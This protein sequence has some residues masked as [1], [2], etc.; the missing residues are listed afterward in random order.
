MYHLLND[1]PER[2]FL[3]GLGQDARSPVYNYRCF[4]LRQ[5][6]SATATTAGRILLGR[7]DQGNLTVQLSVAPNE[8]DTTDYWLNDWV[9]MTGPGSPLAL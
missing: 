4:R 2:P 8:A 9:E 5:S 1:A 7:D 3:P 6:A